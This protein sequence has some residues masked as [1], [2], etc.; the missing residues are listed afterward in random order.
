MQHDLPMRSAPPPSPIRMGRFLPQARDVEAELKAEGVDLDAPK[1]PGLTLSALA[2]RLEQG[3]SSREWFVTGA[4]D[5]AIFSD[6]FEFKDDSVSTKGIK[7][8]ALGVRKLFDQVDS[9]EFDRKSYTCVG[10]C[11]FFVLLPFKHILPSLQFKATS[12]VEL[13]GVIPEEDKRS[14]R[15]IWRLE[16]RV[17]L[18][19]KPSIPPYVVTTTLGVNGQGLI[20]S[21]LDEFSVPGWQLLLGALLGPWAGPVPAP[22]VELLRAKY[23][24][25][26]AGGRS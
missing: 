10:I 8:Y 1:A 22:P 18:L 26:Q 5:T 15:V 23:G 20:E 2:E 12:R 24:E 25:Q 14:L 9:D 19:W 3:L 7:S 16:G 4:V 17:N 13:I 6:E 21:Q 11:G